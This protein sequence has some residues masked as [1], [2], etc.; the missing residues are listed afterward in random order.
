MYVF[1]VLYQT[2]TIHIQHVKALSHGTHL[3]SESGGG[4][5]AGMQTSQGP[6]LLFDLEAMAAV[7]CMNPSY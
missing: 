5:T 1:P 4:M 3:G 6:T 2:S 7:N